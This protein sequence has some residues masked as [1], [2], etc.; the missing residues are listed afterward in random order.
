MRAVLATLAVAA[1]LGGC[2]SFTEPSGKTDLTKMQQVRV[3]MTQDEVRALAGRP[4]TMGP[5]RSDGQTWI[6]S[7]ANETGRTAE[8]DV[9]FDSSGKVR[10]V[11]S[12]KE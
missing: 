6:Y 9:D 5:N 10:R 8:Y 3:G 4:T 11:T 1:F 12:R 7:I 2:A